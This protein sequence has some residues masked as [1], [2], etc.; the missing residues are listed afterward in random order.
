MPCDVCL[1]ITAVLEDYRPNINNLNG[2]P[3]PL[4][5]KP[6]ILLTITPFHIPSEPISRSELFG[7]NSDK[8]FKHDLVAPFGPHSW[9]VTIVLVSLDLPGACQDFS[10]PNETAVLRAF[11]YDVLLQVLR[12]LLKAF[13]CS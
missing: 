3:T 9:S 13:L 6:K 5:R 7:S 12:C 4:S 10:G 11:S 8:P 1:D 2:F